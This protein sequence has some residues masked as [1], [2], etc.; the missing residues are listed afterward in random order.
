MVTCGHRRHRENLRRHRRGNRR[1]RIRRHRSIHRRM[2]SHWSSCCRCYGSRSR[3]K[4]WK[5]GSKMSGSKTNWSMSGPEK[6]RKCRSNRCGYRCF[7]ICWKNGSS[8][9]MWSSRCEEWSN[10]CCAQWTNRYREWSCRIRSSFRHGNCPY[11]CYK[12]CIRNDFW[13]W[14]S[15]R[16]HGWLWSRCRSQVWP[17]CRKYRHRLS[18]CHLQS[19][20]SSNGWHCRYQHQSR[21]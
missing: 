12:D 18:L 6:S 19:R 9:K 16:L 5:S 20:R 4:S 1:R 2:T 21:E 11:R 13:Y 7:L 17:S 14:W 3:T 8:R 10:R 15:N